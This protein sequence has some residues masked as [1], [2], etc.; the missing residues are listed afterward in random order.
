MN[1]TL[2]VKL[3]VV[4][5]KHYFFIPL[6]LAEFFLHIV[7]SHLADAVP[8]PFLSV[9]VDEHFFSHDAALVSAFVPV[10]TLLEA[11]SDFAAPFLSDLQHS[12]FVPVHDFEHCALTVVIV[13]IIAIARI[14]KYF[15]ILIDFLF[16]N[17]NLN[18]LSVCL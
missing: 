1:E 9:Q 5:A 13:A 6:Q 16:L 4:S 14:K 10:L 3:K 2:Y 17:L 8:L 18:Y 11:P 12:F 7:V 15:F